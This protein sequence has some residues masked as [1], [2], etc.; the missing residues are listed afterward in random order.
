MLYFV[1]L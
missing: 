1:V